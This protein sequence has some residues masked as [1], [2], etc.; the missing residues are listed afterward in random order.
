MTDP[1][2]SLTTDT[3]ALAGELFAPGV[4]AQAGPPSAPASGTGVAPGAHSHG[5]PA[6]TPSSSRRVLA[7]GAWWPALATGRWTS[8]Q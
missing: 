2:T 4:G 3:A 1:N 5:G 7:P 8:S 6:A